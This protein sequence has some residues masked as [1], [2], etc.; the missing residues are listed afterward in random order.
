MNRTD[1]MLAIL[2]ELQAR[3]TLR[4]ED[5]A[6]R[7]EVSRRS[8]YRDLQALSETGVPILAVPGRG[9]SLME[10]Y[11]LPPLSF[12][13]E[14]ALALL[15]GADAVRQT[16]RIH[17]AAAGDASDKIM[18]ILPEE[19]RRRVAEL[20]GLVRFIQ[21]QRPGRRSELA[22]V[23]LLREA[24]IAGR[25]VE[26]DYVKRFAEA[27]PPERRVVDPHALSNISGAWYLVGHCHARGARRIFRVQR[28]ER[29]TVL[30][31]TFRRPTDFT[32]APPDRAD[33]RP[34]IIRLLIDHEHVRWVRE[35][36]SFFQ[37]AEEEHPE[38]LVIVLASRTV[39]E[40][41]HWIIGLGSH[42]RV[43]DPP[44]VAEAVRI[45]VEK[46]LERYRPAV[47]C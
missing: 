32:F 25:S 28:M 40:V 30:D 21:P 9:Y 44:E 6:E 35:S 39:A 1:R 41:L 24:A 22:D 29:L 26:F 47:H 27:V 42:A 33:E 37:I 38:G 14:E 17:G 2:L 7:L 18:A 31:A 5:L 45:E 16:L 13:S 43:I 19:S 10:G 23:E 34:V 8:I 12:T 36:P 46:I 4:A 15:L 11:F 20:R 3:G